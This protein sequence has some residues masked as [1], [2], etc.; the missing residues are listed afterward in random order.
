MTKPKTKARAK[1][2]RPLRVEW[3]IE[4]T[5]R[6]FGSWLF[7]KMHTKTELL[8]MMRSYDEETGVPPRKYRAV[9]VEIYAVEEPKR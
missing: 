1:K 7:E 9:R 5:Q 8:R 4:R 3:W 2:E 6:E